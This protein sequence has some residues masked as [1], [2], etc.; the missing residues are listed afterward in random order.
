MDNCSIDIL[1]KIK[2]M[3]LFALGNPTA[4]VLRDFSVNKIIKPKYPDIY[5]LSDLLNKASET[6]VKNN[7][8]ITKTK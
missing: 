8:V 2:S 3:Q 5:M 7:Y 6:E 1:E 4:K